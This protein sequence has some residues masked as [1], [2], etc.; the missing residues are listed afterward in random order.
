MSHSLIVINP[1]KETSEKNV[2]DNIQVFSFLNQPTIS[3]KS[4]ENYER[5]LRQFFYFYKGLGIK[6]ITTAHI[7]LYLKKLNKA[8]S[9]KNLHLRVISAFYRYS[10]KVKYVSEN[11]TQALRQEKVPEKFRFKILHRQQI[12]RMIDLEENHSKKM[13]LKI[14]YYTGLR[15]S[16]AISL[17]EKSF[18][19]AEWNKGAY[20]TVVGKGSKV[21]SVFLPFDFYL[22]INEYIKTSTNIEGLLFFDPKTEKGLTRFQAFRIIQRAAKRAKVDPLPSPHWFRHSNATHSIEAGAPVH[23]VQASLGHS[24][25]S[26]TGKYLHASWTESNAS[27]L[28]FEKDQK[29]KSPVS[30]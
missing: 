22:Q 10:F 6:D 5:I 26:T 1:Q 16:E 30:D 7:T 29:T 13:L 12:Q 24:S 23:V 17:N 8:P 19:V 11:P 20:M 21:R 15:V 25:I 18:R 27:Y 9:T 4:Q 3:K 14:L 2:S 28:I